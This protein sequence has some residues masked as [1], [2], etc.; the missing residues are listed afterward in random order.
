MPDY[1]SILKEKLD[2][3]RPIF[4]NSA[5][6]AIFHVELSP[7]SA[8]EQPK[9][10]LLN[11]VYKKGLGRA[12]QKI[13]TEWE[14]R[15]CVIN[16]DNKSP[17]GNPPLAPH[18][19]KQSNTADSNAST[20]FKKPFKEKRPLLPVPSDASDPPCVEANMKGL[21]QTSSLDPEITKSC[22]NHSF[23]TYTQCFE[24]FTFLNP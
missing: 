8:R 17:K 24:K 14:F 2:I 6:P 22:K 4:L 20:K 10:H 5:N 15:D 18:L 19:R 12:T 1:I 16:S 13:P 21:T 3:R 7:T 11:P 23:S 9:S